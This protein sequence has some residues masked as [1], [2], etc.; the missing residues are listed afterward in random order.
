MT[1]LPYELVLHLLVNINN[2]RAFKNLVLSSR[3]FYEVFNQNKNEIIISVM[4]NSKDVD[5]IFLY[6]IK[7]KYI[8]GIKK[9][10]D[11][12][13]G[14]KNIAMRYS[15]KIGNLAMI[16]YLV[17][18]L[19]ANNFHEA[20]QWSIRHGHLEI[21]KYMVNKFTENNIDVDVDIY[22]NLAIVNGHSDIVKY[23]IDYYGFTE[24]YL[25]YY[26]ETSFK[27]NRMDIIKYIISVGVGNINKALRLSAKIGD[28]E[29]V[30]FSI[31]N[32]ANDF[33]GALESSAEN[34]HLEVVKLLVKIII[35]KDLDLDCYEALE[36][37][38]KN[39]HLEVIEYL[40]PFYIDEPDAS[41]FLNS[42]AEGGHLDIVKLLIYVLGARVR[43]YNG[44]LIGGVRYGHMHIVKYAI[45]ELGTNNFNT[46]LR[47]SATNDHLEVIEYLIK[48][49]ANRFDNAL[50]ISV[51]QNHIEIVKC[52]VEACTDE[53]D[54]DLE[55]ALLVSIREG[56]AEITTYL[57][58][59]L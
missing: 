59:K 51:N 57:E 52:L 8:P 21:A 25:D 33:S 48:A 1:Q 49:G 34:G 7:E 43:I 37:S 40:L 26:L 2:V 4:R 13:I 56:H 22:I 30:E 3:D 53:F 20:L 29:M 47:V 50:Q 32:N 54:I 12:S 16:K 46:A 55:Y 42:A 10:S 17:D 27:Y 23:F 6:F 38:V 39:G 35:D 28:L 18:E 41:N 45:E 24:D 15:A 44:V 36:S 14:T 31:E 58:S 11:V 5:K 9:Y 19:G